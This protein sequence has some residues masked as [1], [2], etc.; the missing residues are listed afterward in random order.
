VVGPQEVAG[1]AVAAGVGPQ[2]EEV[3]I[4]TVPKKKTGHFSIF[5]TI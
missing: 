5:F 4:W 3:R 2:V 1:E